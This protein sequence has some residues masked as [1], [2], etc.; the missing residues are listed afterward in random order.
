M[1][2]S[3]VL[4]DPVGSEGLELFIEARSHCEKLFH[5]KSEQRRVFEVE[6]RGDEVR[7]ILIIVDSVRVISRM[8]SNSSSLSIFT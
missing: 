7:G 2:V 1:S 3:C 6:Q 5:I 4:S 8:S